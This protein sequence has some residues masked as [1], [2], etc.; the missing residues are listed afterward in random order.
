MFLFIN[1]YYLYHTKKQGCSKNGN[2]QGR[3][4]GKRINFRGNMTFNEIVDTLHSLAN[5][6]K[7]VFK[8]KKFGIVAQ[9]SLGIYHADLKVLAKDIGKDSGLAIRLFDTGI[10]EAR[11][12]CSKIFDPKDL[13]YL[14]MDDWAMTFE[15]WE[16]CDSFCMGLFAKTPL[17]SAKIYE[18]SSR[19]PEFEKRAA[20]A[21]LAAFCMAEKRALNETFEA[22]LPILVR[23]SCD[24]R[25]YVKKAVNWALRSIGKRNVDL[26]QK[27]L[28]TAE[29]ILSHETKSGNWIAKD[30]I[31]E[32][33]KEKLNVLDYP[34]NIYR[35]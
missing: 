18:W 31:R 27:A 22:F 23:E 21:T 26:K 6:E 8:K 25:I 3:R 35:P 16:I 15:N 24:D 11:I 10:F 9:N 19:G 20:F 4:K 13:T 29:K 32:L 28:A 5:P 34:R 17:A 2:R 12:L 30:A 14:Q 33:T 7:V 1:F